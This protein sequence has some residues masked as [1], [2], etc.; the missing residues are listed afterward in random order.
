MRLQRRT[1]ILIVAI[2]LARGSHLRAQQAPAPTFGASV[3][4]RSGDH[5]RVISAIH[6]T[7]PLTTKW[8][9]A[10]WLCRSTADQ[11]DW[12]ASI[13]ARRLFGPGSGLAYLGGGISWTDEVSEVRAL[14]HWGAVAIGGAE[15]PLLFLSSLTARIRLFA[16]L[17]LFTHHYATFQHLVGARL[18]LGG[19]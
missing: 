16:E 6:L 18:R 7:I 19:R 2:V 8:D 14:G 13:A 10:P 12:R 4:F 3:G 9:L 11:P 17:Q 5:D 1:A 15:L